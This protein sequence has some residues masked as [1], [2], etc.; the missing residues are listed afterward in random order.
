MRKVATPDQTGWKNLKLHWVS[1]TTEILKMWQCLILQ[2]FNFCS[3]LCVPKWSLVLGQM[4]LTLLATNPKLHKKH[5]EPSSASLLFVVHWV[6]AAGN[7]SLADAMELPG[8][9]RHQAFQPLRAMQQGRLEQ[10]NKYVL[11]SRSLQENAHFPG[12]CIQR[13]PTRS[14][15]YRAAEECDWVHSSVSPEK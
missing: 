12:C 10:P 9:I 5:T 13:L 4:L 15:G 7:V 2:Y 6:T 11:F 3:Y 8:S 1:N 14:T